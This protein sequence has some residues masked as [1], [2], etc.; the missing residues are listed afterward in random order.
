MAIGL[1]CGSAFRRRTSKRRGRGAWG[2]AGA[3]PGGGTRRDRCE[4]ALKRGILLA[5]VADTRDL[6]EN[7]QLAAREFFLPLGRRGADGPA[8]GPGPFAKF[9]LTPIVKERPAPG[10]GGEPG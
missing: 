10:M 5:P 1:P 7:A 9:S 2:G 3:A 6:L 4:G 8:V